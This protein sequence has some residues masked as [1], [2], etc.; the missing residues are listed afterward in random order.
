MQPVGRSSR[1]AGPSSVARPG[2]RI[3]APL[4]RNRVR[5]GQRPAVHD[6]PAAGAR[7][8]D[9]AERRAAP[10][11]APSGL[12]Q[13]EAV[14]VVRSARA[15]ERAREVAASGRPL[16]QVELAFFTRPVRAR[17]RRACRRRRAACPPAPSRRDE[18]RDRLRGSP[19][20]VA[21]RRR[22]AGAQLRAIRAERD[23]PRFVPPRSMPMRASGGFS[24]RF[25]A[26]FAR[27]LESKRR[28]PG[29]RRTS[30]PERWP[31]TLAALSLAFWLGGRQELDAPGYNHATPGSQKGR[32]RAT[33]HDR[34]APRP[35]GRG[36]QP[37]R[38]AA[39]TTAEAKSE[40]A[41]RTAR[42]HADPDATPT[43]AAARAAHVPGRRHA[44]HFMF[45]DGGWA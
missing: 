28:P 17:A 29:A 37:A 35:R 43:G 8:D 24:S 27:R 12:R 44:V 13:R 25:V 19:V 10:R 4:A 14:G 34:L 39:A 3:V 22:R 2:Q 30:R 41:S 7:P 36:L 45:F 38:R 1:R 31:V 42:E 18:G 16:S 23:A 20:V 9:H 21:R 6:H 32:A 40:P 15:A 5:A 26:A 11:A 33:K